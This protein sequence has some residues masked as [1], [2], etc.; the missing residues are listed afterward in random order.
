MSDLPQWHSIEEAAEFL[1]ITPR[2]MR[3]YL[4]LHKHGLVGVRKPTGAVN[5]PWLAVRWDT[6]I[7]F[8][9][10][11]SYNIAQRSSYAGR[12]R[13]GTWKPRDQCPRCTAVSPGNE[14]CD[15]CREL[16]GR[17]YYHRRADIALPSCH[18]ASLL[19]VT[20]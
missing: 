13:H 19:G 18:N 14:L 17:P 9:N 2:T 3:T 6:V 4:T 7:A 15:L 8:A 1:N 20:T 12:C 16:E 10:T 5:R 11:R